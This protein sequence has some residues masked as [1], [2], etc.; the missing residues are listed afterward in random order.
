M[1]R[2]LSRLLVLVSLAA[3][4]VQ[5][6]PLPDPVRIATEGGNPPFNYVEDG[7]PAGFEVDLAEALCKAAGLTCRIVLHQWDGIIRGLEG[8]EYDA[9]MASLAITPKRRSRISFSRS[10]YRIPSSY[11]ARR[12]DQTGPLDPAALKGRAVG[13]AAHSPQ[14][15]YLE[16]RAPEADIRSFDSVKDAGYD[17]RLG[18]LDL[19][20]GDKRELTEILA[21]PD[22]AACCRLVGDVPPGDP[23]LGEG[24]GIGLRKGDDA[25]REA[26]DRAIAAVIADGTYDRIRAKY[27]PFDTK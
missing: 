12:D 3:S 4:P 26:F 10:Y 7:K 23:L 15:A 21:L 8:A 13:A 11:M 9:I 24:V 6:A 18:R 25:L 5:A 27:L 14:L 2:L 19:V 20:L 16:A 1:S 17:L 22:G